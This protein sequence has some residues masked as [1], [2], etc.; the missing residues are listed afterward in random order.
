M[1]RDRPAEAAA[2]LAESLALRM[3]SSIGSDPRLEATRARLERAQA[4]AEAQVV[5]TVPEAR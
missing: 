2:L 5:S 1:A 4:S 3:R